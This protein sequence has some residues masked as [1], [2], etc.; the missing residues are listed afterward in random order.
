MD[1]Y[2]HIG[3][4]LVNLGNKTQETGPDGKVLLSYE[5]LGSNR[6]HHQD[7]TLTQKWMDGLIL[8]IHDIVV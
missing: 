1:C 8:S 5:Q 3:E 6:T 2:G 7:T 4:A